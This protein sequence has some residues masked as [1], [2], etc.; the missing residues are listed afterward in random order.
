MTSAVVRQRELL[1]GEWDEVDPEPQAPRKRATAEELFAIQCRGYRLPPFE[2]QQ[3]FAKIPF[4]RKWRFDFS[5]PAYKLAVEI[6][7]LAVKRLAGQLVVLGRHASIQGFKDDCEK[8]AHA[9]VLG[10]GVMRFEQSMVRSKFAIEMLMRAL[11]A[12]GWQRP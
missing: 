6:E 10:W 1:P 12:R 5:F 7:G 2:Q 11:V 8:Y 4:G 9:V 3:Q